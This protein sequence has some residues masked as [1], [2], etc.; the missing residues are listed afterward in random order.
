MYPL[1]SETTCDDDQF[2]CT[3]GRCIDLSWHCD[4]DDDC[5]DQSDEKD[6]REY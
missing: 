6:C 5:S 2:R 3:N 1:F 4:Q